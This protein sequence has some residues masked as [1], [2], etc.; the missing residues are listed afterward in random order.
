MKHDDAP[1]PETAREPSR[2]KEHFKNKMRQGK[3][4]QAES[5]PRKPAAPDQ[6]RAALQLG[7]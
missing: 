1:I 6:G 3:L 7:L 5:D 2:R 4:Q